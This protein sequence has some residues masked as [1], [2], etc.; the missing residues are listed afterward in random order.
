MTDCSHSPAPCSRAWLW[1]GL[2]TVAMWE[3]EPPAED[4]L[5]ADLLLDLLGRFP[6]PLTIQNVMWLVFFIGAGEL[7]HRSL[8]GSREGEQLAMRLLPEDENTVLGQKDLGRFYREIRRS[9][10]EEQYWLQRLLK[11][12]ILQFQASGST[13]QVNAIFNANVE[14]YQHEIELR[15]NLL[16]YLVWLIPTLGFVGTVTGIALSL[17]EAGQFFSMLAEQGAGA[18]APTALMEGLVQDLGVA[19]YTTLLALLQSAVLMAAMH[20]VQGREEGFLNQ[21]AQY[22]LRNLVNRL[23]ER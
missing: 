19:F 13:D 5:L 6:Y 18:S 1:I 3:P 23:Y 2:L 11:S 7:L 4:R 22:C 8:A 14:L 16:R 15:Y 12:A 21:A 17:A 20:L 9:D 10:P